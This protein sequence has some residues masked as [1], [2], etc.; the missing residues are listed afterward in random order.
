MMDR[1]EHARHPGGRGRRGR[2]GQPARHP[3]AGGP[4]RRR[5]RLGRRGAPP[6]RPRPLLGDRPRP[7]PARRGV[8]RA[9]AD[10]PRRGTGGGGHRRDGLLRPPGRR[11]RAAA[12]GVG[13]HRQAARRRRAARADRPDR[14]AAAGGRGAACGRAGSARERGAV[15]A[16]RRG[17]RVPD[18]D[19]PPRSHGRLLQPIRRAPDRLHSSGGPRPRLPRDPP[20][21][22]VIA[23]PSP[24]SWHGHSRDGPRRATRT[25]SSAGTARSG[26]S[27]GTHGR[28]P[29]SR[30]G[31]P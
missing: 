12:G 4:P 13:L 17:R 6:R 27:P 30:A 7:P 22:V 23:A 21:G 28:W 9:A 20:A 15:P 29:T 2:P 5:G 24:R 19:P 1:G 10:P 11:R 25:R 26:G 18:R 8:R 31:R 3:R 16:A 14:R